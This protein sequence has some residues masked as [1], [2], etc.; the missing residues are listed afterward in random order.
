M[1]SS[2]VM[3]LN[4]F[5]NMYCKARWK[6]N[7]NPDHL[8]RRAWHLIRSEEGGEPWHEPEARGGRGLSNPSVKHLYAGDPRGLEGLI[9]E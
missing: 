7:V 8:I 3:V 1:E 9:Y 5:S 2:G 4:L 6:K